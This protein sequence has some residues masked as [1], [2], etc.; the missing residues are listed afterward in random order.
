MTI[1]IFK[2][3]KYLCDAEYGTD[4]V[5]ISYN[6]YLPGKGYEL[7]KDTFITE[8]TCDWTEINSLK[9]KI[10]YENFLNTMVKKNQEVYQAMCTTVVNNIL[11]GSPSKKQLMRMMRSIKILDNTFEPPYINLK[12]RWQCDFMTKMCQETLLSLIEE[13]YNQ[14]RLKKLFNALKSI[15]SSLE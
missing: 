6:R 13:T 10:P 11:M 14:K 4:L 8:P 12:C 7:F 2:S 9:E 3:A 5:E 15:E 1:S